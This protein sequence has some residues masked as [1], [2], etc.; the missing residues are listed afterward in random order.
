MKE[1]PADEFF[2]GEEKIEEIENEADSPVSES[3]EVQL[4]KKV[5]P[6]EALAYKNG[7]LTRLLAI[8]EGKNGLNMNRELIF[9]LL[10]RLTEA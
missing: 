1:E 4:M 7:C 6:I 10:K 2:T 9:F 8:R 5:K 3:T